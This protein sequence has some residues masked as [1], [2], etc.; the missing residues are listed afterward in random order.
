VSGRFFRIA[1]TPFDLP[2]VCQTKCK[3]ATRFAVTDAIF[4]RGALALRVGLLPFYAQVSWND[5]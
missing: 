4:D 3:H 2:K 5:A 1:F